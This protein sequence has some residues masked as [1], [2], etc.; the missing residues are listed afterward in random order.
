MKGKTPFSVHCL[1]SFVSHLFLELW[2]QLDNLL[3]NSEKS[4]LCNKVLFKF[5]NI[6]RN[7]SL[8]VILTEIYYNKQI[9]TCDSWYWIYEINMANMLIIF[10]CDI[11]LCTN[12]CIIILQAHESVPN[13]RQANGHWK[14]IAKFGTKYNIFKIVSSS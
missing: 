6:N 10:H 7:I 2:K 4:V 1:K 12:T 13:S 8:K 9:Q 5:K 3:H 11:Y 14:N